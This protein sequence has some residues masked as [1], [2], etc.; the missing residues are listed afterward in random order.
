MGRAL[1][2]LHATHDDLLAGVAARALVSW[3][4]GAVRLV[5][6]HAAFGGVGAG[7]D[8]GTGVLAKLVNTSLVGGTLGVVATLHAGAGDVWISLESWRTGTDV[9]VVDSLAE[10]V[11]SARQVVD[12]AHGGAGALGAPVGL[13]ALIVALT[14]HR[15]AFN[16]GVSVEVLLTGTDG[17]VIFNSTDGVASTSAGV[18]ADGIDASGWVSALV[19]SRATHNDGH[20]GLTGAVLGGVE[21][22]GALADETLDRQCFY[23]VTCCRWFAG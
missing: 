12:T 3:W 15:F 21:A 8:D 20:Q 6:E 2:I 19:V 9:L 4:A 18:L 16:L 10:G 23:D 1:V 7:V 5:V 17:S 14:S 11:T 22:F 13:F